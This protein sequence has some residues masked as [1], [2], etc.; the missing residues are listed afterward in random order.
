M[1]S[2]RWTCRTAPRAGCVRCRTSSPT[3]RTSTSPGSPAPT[4]CAISWSDASWTPTSGTTTRSPRKTA[5]VQPTAA[6]PAATAHG[7]RESNRPHHH[8]DRRQQRVRLGDRRAG[9]P[10][11]RPLRPPPHAHPPAV[12][13]VGD[14]GGRRRDGA[15]ARAVDGPAGPHR[16]HVLP[17][18]RA[19]ARQ[20]G[21]GARAGAARRH[22]AVPGGRQE[23]G[24][25]GADRALHGRGAAAAHRARRP[26]P[27]RLRPRGAGREG[28]DVRPAEGHPGRVAGRARHR[29]A[30]AGAHHPLTAARTP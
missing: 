18:G 22:R 29:G 7:P 10:R 20:G 26:P 21:R 28:R 2:P 24:R 23:A 30:V 25:G 8:G 6:A 1:T 5:A 13:A 3:S 14:R 15:A 17:D 9:G 11:R 19:A 16:C 27:A 4:W 12:R